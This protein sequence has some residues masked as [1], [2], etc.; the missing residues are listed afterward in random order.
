MISKN[1]L[2]EI[3]KLM[4]MT[5]WQQEKHYTQYLAL[6][7]MAEEPLVFKGGTYLWFAH[8]LDRFSED[9]DFTASERLP[10]GLADKVSKDLALLGAHFRLYAHYRKCEPC[11][12]HTHCRRP[13]HLQILLPRQKLLLCHKHTHC[14]RFEHCHIPALH[15]LLLHYSIMLSKNFLPKMNCWRYR[16]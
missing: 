6:L 14:R 4:G 11:Q 2:L 16:N 13:A 8:S 1:E 3:S 9:L 7:S 10:D 12:T 15:S 5:P